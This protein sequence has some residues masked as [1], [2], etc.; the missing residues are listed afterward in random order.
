MLKKLLPVVFLG[1]CVILRHRSVWI[2][3][4]A[5][6][7]GFLFVDRRLLRRMV[8]AV[9]LATCLA[10]AYVYFAGD[11]DNSVGNEVNKS[12]TDDRTWIFRVNM[13]ESLLSQQAPTPMNVLFG[14]DMG[15]GYAV[16]NVGQQETIDIPPHNEF[17]AQ[18]LSFGVSGVLFLI[19]FLVLPL[20]QLWTLPS[21]DLQAV[22]PSVSAWV[23]VILGIIVYCVP[24]EPLSDTYALLAIANAMVIQIALKAKARKQ[25]DPRL[26][27]LGLTPVSRAPANTVM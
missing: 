24:Y 22:V 1:I 12:A 5:G 7:Y 9:V 21:E 13:W 10:G 15:G 18:Y 11:R 23:A 27:E 6:I 20:R 2:S 8:P 3:L 19:G 4:I 16:F 25:E 26:Y 14:R 17:I